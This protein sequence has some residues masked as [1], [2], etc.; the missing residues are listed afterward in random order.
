MAGYNE[1]LI[2]ASVDNLQNAYNSLYTTMSSSMQTRFIDEMGTGWACQDAVDFFTTSTESLNQLLASITYNY[3]DAVEKI[4]AAGKRWAEK[5]G[6]SYTPRGFSGQNGKVNS[7][8]IHENIGGE[9]GADTN[10]LDQAIVELGKL[11]GEADSALVD[12]VTAVQTCGFSDDEGA[13]Q[14]AVTQSLTKLKSDVNELI[15]GISQTI[16][17]KVRATVENYGAIVAANASQFS[18]IGQG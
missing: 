1:E 15:S 2:H 7:S 3:N 5:T 11:Q 17:E 18:S 16:N 9:R 4:E 8:S 6:G 10:I 12:S 14:V 13:Q